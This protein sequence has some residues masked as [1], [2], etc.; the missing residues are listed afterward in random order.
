MQKHITLN[1]AIPGPKSQNLLDRRK[2]VVP[3][4]ISNGCTAFVKQANG[5]LVEDM[6]G[7]KFIDYFLRIGYVEGMHQRFVYYRFIGGIFFSFFFNGFTGQ[8]GEFKHIHVMLVSNFQFSYIAFRKAQ[9]GSAVICPRTGNN[10]RTQCKAHLFNAW[11]I[12]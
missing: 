2:R 5:A 1:T 9:F 8:H 10:R 4:G 6:D 7:N 11:I 12:F 3:R